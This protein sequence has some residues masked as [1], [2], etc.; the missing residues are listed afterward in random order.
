MPRQKPHK[1][2]HLV[3]RVTLEVLQQM[4]KRIEDYSAEEQ[5]A[6]Y[7]AA[8]DAE[9]FD[10]APVMRRAVRQM[11]ESIDVAREAKE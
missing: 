3:Q 4:K 2:Q 5:N 8:L 9:P 7:G 10:S 6:L 11:V 1:G